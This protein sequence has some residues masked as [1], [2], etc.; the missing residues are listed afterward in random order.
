MI[1]ADDVSLHY[2]ES[3]ALADVSLAIAESEIVALVGSSGSGKSSLLHC[4]SGLVRPTAG[5]VTV[6]G[7]RIHELDHESSA[8]FRRQHLGFV[9]QFSELIPE[10]TLSENIAL[11]LELGGAPRRE[12]RSRTDE[13]I[14]ALGIGDRANARP[15]HVSGGQAQRAAVAR[16]VAHRPSVLFADE[17]TGALDSANAA[18]V[19]ALMLDLARNDRTTVVIAT[20]DQAVANSA[21]RLIRLHD[22]RALTGQDAADAD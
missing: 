16:A 20:H 21:D 22:G 4:L 13:L 2:G 5:S 15:H 12:I 17:P 1:R 10:L 9:F 8:A 19:L 3:P 6:G 7:Q 18:T 11:P 14:E